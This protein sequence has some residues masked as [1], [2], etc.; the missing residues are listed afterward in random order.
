[1][2]PIRLFILTV[3]MAALA[4]P[5]AV[6][7]ADASSVAP[8]CAPAPMSPLHKRIRDEAA[9]GLPALIGFVN[10]SQPI[11]QLRV[12]DAVAWLDAER[13]R[14]AECMTALAR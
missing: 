7:A 2:S 11:Y 5:L 10:I 13:E 9:R 8:A 1:M 12:V 4:T 6:R 3:A 14:T